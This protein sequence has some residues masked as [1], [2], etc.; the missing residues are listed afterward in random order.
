MRECLS[1]E[2]YQTIEGTT[3]SEHILALIYE[4]LAQNSE[5]TL[6]DALSQTLRRIKTWAA[7]YN[8][9]VSLN[10]ILSDGQSM[11]VSR[12]AYPDPPPS[13]YWL[14]VSQPAT[15]VLV[16]SEP[17]DADDQMRSH[18]GGCWQPISAN[19]LLTV[20]PMQTVE[21]HAL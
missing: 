20:S 9:R 19:T 11:V 13:L 18:L 16:A 14:A 6:V 4:T 2:R 7:S 3:D 17:I 10:V 1:D 5:L 15:G 12:F 8:I 21:T